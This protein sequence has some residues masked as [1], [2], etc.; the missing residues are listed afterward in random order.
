MGDLTVTCAYM[1]MKNW[2]HTPLITQ[3]LL[4]PFQVPWCFF[5]TQ[6]LIF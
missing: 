3:P 6:T 5:Y 4:R 1:C 2:D